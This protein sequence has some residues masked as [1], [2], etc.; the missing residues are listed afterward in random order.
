M[1]TQTFKAWWADLRE[2]CPLAS[3]YKDFAYSLYA[4]NHTIEEAGDAI[5]AHIEAEMNWERDYLGSREDEL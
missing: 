1:Q 4:T 5:E 3:G 2:F